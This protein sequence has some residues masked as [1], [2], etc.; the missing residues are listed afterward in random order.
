VDVGGCLGHNT[1]A[2]VRTHT[3][4]HYSAMSSKSCRFGCPS[5]VIATVH[6]PGK[7]VSFSHVRIT[8][9]IR[10]A[11]VWR[12]TSLLIWPPIVYNLNAYTSRASRTAHKRVD[13]LSWIRT[14]IKIQMRF[15]CYLRARVQDNSWHLSNLLISCRSYADGLSCN[16]FTD[17]FGTQSIV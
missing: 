12:I 6:R 14:V 11:I 16:Y 13:D 17:C 8:N 3:H 5:T 10:M 7:C 1:R 4:A 15:Q 9:I 2:H